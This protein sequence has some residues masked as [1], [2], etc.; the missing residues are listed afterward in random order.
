[1][2]RTRVLRDDG[3]ASAVQAGC[4]GTEDR[5]EAGCQPGARLLLDERT[6]TRPS[7]RRRALT[8]PL[9]LVL[10]SAQIKSYAVNHPTFRTGC[11]TFGHFVNRSSTRLNLW[12]MNNTRVKEVKSTLTEK[13]AVAVGGDMMGELVVFATFG[14]IV[15]VHGI[16]EAREKAA[17]KA[18]KA[19]E[20]AIAEKRVVS[21]ESTLHALRDELE[22]M[23]VQRRREL[24][25]RASAEQRRLEAERARREQRAT[26]GWWQRAWW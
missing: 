1:V 21:I 24:G 25:E 20:D 3:R 8:F 4:D 12:S 2:S 19:V 15:V 11:V 5:D 22:A 18:E 9:S 10:L 26:R 16:Y 6:V 7:S 14:S 17:H 23:R 13:Q